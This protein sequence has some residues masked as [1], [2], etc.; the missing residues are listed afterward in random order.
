MKKRLSAMV[1]E[2]E[3]KTPENTELKRKNILYL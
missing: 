1:I 2:Y 3:Q